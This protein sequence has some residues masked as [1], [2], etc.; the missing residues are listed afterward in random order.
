MK[1]RG[2][3]QIVE[4]LLMASTV[5]GST[6]PAEPARLMVLTSSFRLLS[7]S[8]PKEIGREGST[9][10][11]NPSPETDPSRN[12]S[13][14]PLDQ[15]DLGQCK[16]RPE[17]AWCSSAAGWAIDSGRGSISSFFEREQMITTSYFHGG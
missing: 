2:L 6:L 16:Q 10:S 13:S 17:G 1:T 4:I 14:A 5:R 7:G 8:I 3:K 9:A 11:P 12:A 15:E